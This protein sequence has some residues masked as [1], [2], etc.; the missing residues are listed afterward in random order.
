MSAPAGAGKVA[1][2]LVRVELPGHWSFAN[3]VVTPEVCVISLLGEGPDCTRASED[4]PKEVQPAISSS[5]F[6]LNVTR[7]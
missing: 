2:W 3:V 7:S 6:G 1:A 4:E 5:G